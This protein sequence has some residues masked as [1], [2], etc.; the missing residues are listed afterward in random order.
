MSLALPNPYRIRIKTE[1][2]STNA[3]VLRAL[4]AGEADGLLV[5]AVRQTQGRGR[6]GRSWHSLPGASLT[7]SVLIRPNPAEEA[8]S[9]RFTALGALA[10]I[11]ALKELVGVKGALKW[12][13]DVLLNGKKTA[14]V[15]AEAAWQGDQLAGLA[16][17]IG[18]NVSAGS[19]PE[20]VPLNFPATNIEKETGIR[21]EPDTLLST[22]LQAITA[23]REI[24]PT[25]E[26]FRV[27]ED[28]L[29][30]KGE[31]AL[32]RNETGETQR[33]RLLKLHD[34]GGLV[35]EDEAGELQTLYSSELTPSS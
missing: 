30:F 11:E 22:I 25:P 24:L 32:L 35:V 29:A 21:L 20:G 31:W 27:W 17:G 2:D 10:V 1:T 18:V 3:D 6:Q 19:V 8:F 4:S 9:G 16:L 13:N 12:P 5:W 26:F 7:F 33:F 28:S 15:L 23:L 14:G 34:D